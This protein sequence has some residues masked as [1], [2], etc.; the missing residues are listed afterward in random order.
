MLH[1]AAGRLPDQG[2]DLDARDEPAVGHDRQML[3]FPESREFQRELESLYDFV[4]PTAAAMWN[5]RWQVT[6]YLAEAPQAGAHELHSRFLTG[7]GVGTANLRR[8]CVESSWESQLEQ[9]GALALYQAIG[10]LEA[11]IDLLPVG[12]R[13]RRRALVHPAH[14]VEPCAREFLD[15][16]KPSVLNERA[17]APSLESS[18]H[19]LPARLEDLLTV[20]RAYKVVR[21]R[22]THHGRQSDEATVEALRRASAVSDGLGYGTKPLQ[23]PTIGS[24]GRVAVSLAAALGACATVLKLVSTLDHALAVTAVGEASTIE[25]WRAAVGRQTYSSVAARRRPRL[26]DFHA[27][28]G[29]PPVADIESLFAMLQAHGLVANA[30]RP[31]REAEQHAGGMPTLEA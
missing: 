6:G 15:A 17:Y 26:E 21:N 16:L 3:F 8:H 24:H 2:S 11:W 12:T 10:H 9:L 23:L 4:N 29:L 20:L 7:S 30:A 27:Q 19:C 25:R 5:L 31:L 13:A 18:R 1:I 14:G 28:T 22:I